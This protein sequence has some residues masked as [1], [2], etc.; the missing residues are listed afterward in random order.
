M[1]GRHV[2]SSTPP[3]PRRRS[4]RA[5][6]LVVED[7]P[8]ARRLYCELLEY[9]G[10][11]T[12]AASDGFEALQ[13]ARELAPDAMLLDLALPGISGWEVARILRA[14]TDTKDLPIL[15]ITAHAT[16]PEIEL[17]REAGCDRVFVKPAKHDELVEELRSVVRHER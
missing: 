10:F 5:L 3:P 1:S 9:H 7:F 12:V 14:S 11:R 2:D 15:A 16:A 6:I 13:M 17:A 8:D 4:R